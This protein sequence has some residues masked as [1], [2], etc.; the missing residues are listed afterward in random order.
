[1]KLF[2]F[3][4]LFFGIMGFAKAQSAQPEWAYT[5]CL[6]DICS[7]CE[8]GNDAYNLHPFSKF[9]Y[10][11]CI[12]NFEININDWYVLEPKQAQSVKVLLI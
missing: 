7:Y 6:R 8:V 11:L 2:V 12:Y 10:C 5:M 3:I 9:Y 1:M 4:F